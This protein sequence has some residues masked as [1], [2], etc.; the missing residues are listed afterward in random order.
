MTSTAIRLVFFPGERAVN[1][2]T[3]G[4]IYVIGGRGER[5]A[6]AGGG[7][8]GFKDRGGHTAERTP[9]G[10]YTLGPKKHVTT[11]SWPMSSIPFGAPLRLTTTGEAEYQQETGAWRLATGPRGVVTLAE[12]AFLNRDQIHPNVAE[13]V[14]DVR[15]IFI[16]SVTR[17]LRMTTWRL[18]DFGRWGWNLRRGGMP[19][20]YFI[21]TTPESEA[22][23]AS[24]Q[25]VLLANSHGC[26]HLVP[27][28]RDRMEEAGYLKEG[29]E[30]EVRRY[31]EHGP[32]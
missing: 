2:T 17:T 7:L 25:A 19:T 11:L 4:T 8:A 23:T 29:V 31:A 30:F 28:D 12:L 10:R 22:A 18:N 3:L 14:A 21:H 6:A 13:L 9:A 5:F 20:A 32:P 1:G 16:D 26:I 15:Q 27:A 24:G